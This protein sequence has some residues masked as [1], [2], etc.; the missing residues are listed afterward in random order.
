M[1]TYNPKNERAKK[2]YFRFLKEADRK[3]ESTIDCVRKAIS[4]YEAYTGLK[5]FATF[6]REQA[7]A[8]KKHLAKTKAE[9]SG[10]PFAKATLHATVNSLKT[11]FK[12]LSCQ[13]GYKSRIR[14]TDIEYL[15]LSNKEV[16]AA[17]Q[18]ALKRFPTPEQI[19]KVVF[20]MPTATVIQRRDR[21]LVAFTIVTGMRDNA[22]ASLRLKHVDL[23]HDLVVQDPLEVRTKFSKKIVTYF[24]P[25]GAELKQVVIEWVREL[26]GNLIYGNDDPVFPRK[27]VTQDENLC[28]TVDGLEPGFWANA[29]PI[30]KI[31]RQAFA[32]AGLAYFNP[33]SFRDTL[34][35]LGKKLCRTPEEF[36]AWSKNL[37]HEEMLTTFRSY[38]SIDPHRQGELIK[39]LGVERNEEDKLDQL[40]EMMKRLDPAA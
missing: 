38:G 9:R 37:G 18:P 27:R 10:E 16:R 22:I 11:F 34:V 26:R 29:E 17:R 8:F 32:G 23:D 4:R 12:W 25:V 6:N 35:Q 13:P 15:N 3:S 36:E 20:S 30:R 28:F 21:A 24:F 19:R 39:S 7:V 1:R 2:D 40:M 5:D 33:H 14:V 31:F